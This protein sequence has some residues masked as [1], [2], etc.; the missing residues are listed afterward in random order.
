MKLTFKKK[1]DQN[2]ELTLGIIRYE[3]F[4]QEHEDKIIASFYKH[5]NLHFVQKTITAKPSLAGSS[6][7]S[8]YTPM[9]LSIKRT[10]GIDIGGELMHELAHRLLIGNGIAVSVEPTNWQYYSHRQIYLFLYDVWCDILGQD[11]ANEAV[12]REKDLGY[13]FYNKAWE[14]AMSMTYEQRQEMIKRHKYSAIYYLNR[15]IKAA[16]D[17]NRKRQ[18]HGYVETLKDSL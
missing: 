11:G 6:S 15:Q 1:I 16:D 13:P 12:K 7:G 8:G 2:L 5:T 18:L 10:D 4:W 14:W 9:L 17:S 3:K